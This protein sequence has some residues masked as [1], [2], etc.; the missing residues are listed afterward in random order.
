M[1]VRLRR[2]SCD[3]K[4]VIETAALGPGVGAHWQRSGRGC[5]G[6]R[7]AAVDIPRATHIV[8][9][10]SVSELPVHCERT[11]APRALSARRSPARFRRWGYGAAASDVVQR[12]ERR[13]APLRGR[14]CIPAPVI[15]GAERMRRLHRR[16]LAT[17]DPW[18]C[19]CR[20]SSVLHARTRLR[21]TTGSV[22]SSGDSV[23]AHRSPGGRPR[24]DKIIRRA[25]RVPGY[26]AGAAVLEAELKRLEA[27]YS[28]F[29]AGRLP[30]PP[31]ETR[32][33]SRHGQAHRSAAHRQLRLPLQVQH[34]QA[35]FT[36]FIELWDRG[37]RAR[38]EGGRGPSRSR[39]RSAERPKEPAEDAAS[40][41]SPRSGIR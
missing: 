17:G 14:C 31:W 16:A 8:A 11:A 18:W 29:F 15:D 5:R 40:C 10:V 28:M 7:K 19:R 23:D 32:S 9:A 27:E 33:A 20:S 34:V 2:S 37:L 36:T 26:R 1:N 4:R 12:Q 30:R 22:K 39:V 6:I 25:G 41:T 38:E 13:P 3:L 24:Y 35:R 21:A